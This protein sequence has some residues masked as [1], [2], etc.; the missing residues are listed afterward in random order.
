MT[1]TNLPNV[2]PFYDMRYTKE[3]GAMTDASRTY[4]DSLSQI[5][6]RLVNQINNGLIMP[7]K[8]TA[9]ITAYGADTAVSV[10]TVWYNSSINKLQLKTG[11]GIIETI[12]SV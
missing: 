7:T 10:G 5:M 4:N 2:P 1:A 6:I 8:T 11:A 9:E 3:N 12:T